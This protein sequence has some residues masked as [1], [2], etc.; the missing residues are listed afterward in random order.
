[1]DWN[2]IS[3]RV[4]SGFEKYK[5]VICVII[6]GL[7]LMMIPQKETE[8]NNPQPAV[9]A[10]A[11][12][13]VTEELSGILSQIRGVGR[14]R[15]MLTEQAARETVYQIDEEETCDTDSRSVSR[16]TV[17]VSGNNGEG[18]LVKT[19]NPPIYLGAI[20]VCQGADDPTV[21]LNV[22][23]AVSAVTGIST[24]RIT[25]LRMK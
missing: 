20:V 8:S 25:V 14:V 10:T 12:V 19:V 16:E 15:V 5:Y 21:R 6:L 24:D 2:G 22:A 1:M 4:A 9:S 23:K 17:L 3:K 18:G 13:S 7:L 11:E